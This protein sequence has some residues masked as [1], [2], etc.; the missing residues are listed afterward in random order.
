[1][2]TKKR[3]SYVDR[4]Q[5]ARDGR[6]HAALLRARTLADRNRSDQELLAKTAFLEALVNSSIDGM[7]VVDSHGRKV[8]QNLRMNELWDIPLEVSGDVDDAAQ[9]LYVLSQV[10][11][12]ESFGETIRYLYAHP[13]ETDRREIHL[14][15]GKIL[16]R[17]SSPVRGHDGRH[18]GRIWTFRDVTSARRSEQALAESEEKLRTLAESIPQM[19]FVCKVDGWNT[20]FNHQWVQYTGMTLEESFGHGWNKAFHA[21]DRGHGSHANEG[22][23]AYEVES[24]IRRAD[25]VY[26]WFLIRGQPLENGDGSVTSWF[27]TCTDIHDLKMA[28]EALLNA[29]DELEARVVQRTK[30]LTIAIDEAQRANHAKSEFLSRMSHELRTPLNAILGFGQILDM[31]RDASCPDKESIQLILK[32]GRH[33]LALINEVLDI[34]GVEAGR[35]G[36]SIEPIAVRDVVAEACALVCPLASQNMIE[37]QDEVDEQE[38]LHVLA[39][40]QR[41]KQVLINLLSNGIKYN[42]PGGRITISC[43][44]APSGRIRLAV[45]DTGIGISREE[46][47][48]LFVPFERLSASNSTIEGSGLGLVLSQRLMTAMH[49]TLEVESE[50][51]KG[52]TFTCE[53]PLAIPP[54]E[55]LAD[56]AASPKDVCKFVPTDHAFTVL[57]I[58]DNL[59]NLRLLQVILASRPGVRLLPAMQGS[60]GMELARQHHPDLILLDLNLPDISGKEVLDLLQQEDAT[61]N[62]PVVVV[63]ADATPPQIARLLAAGAKAYLTKP[64]EVPEFLGTLDAMLLG[65]RP[66]PT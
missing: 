4:R 19:V 52:S 25:G 41:L 56:L 54:L 42:K 32:S 43:S 64:I 34:A 46:R 13:E 38:N 22:R 50:P 7:L 26:R 51:G 60:L 36:L 15:N 53:L 10:K 27:G 57:C 29:Q 35:L 48:K 20:Y 30:D 37:V 17:Y 39:D 44:K 3:R 12:P 65:S 5:S 21:D 63:S 24:R 9:I 55:A 18:Y 31:G 33:L 40:N 58:E 61:K 45:Q 59:S 23:G 6:R 1:M 11:D 62:I 16:D 49:G 2:A 66:K 47:E 8:L 28:E 14:I